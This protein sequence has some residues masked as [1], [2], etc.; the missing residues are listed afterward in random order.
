MK[1][2][3]RF[4]ST[5]VVIAIVVALAL[6]ILDLTDYAHDPANATAYA[7][8]SG[9]RSLFSVE[10]L[11]RYDVWRLK[12]VNWFNDVLGFAREKL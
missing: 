3:L 4:I 9:V 12:I 6:L 11:E 5:L 7:V 2:L 8:D 10:W 1:G